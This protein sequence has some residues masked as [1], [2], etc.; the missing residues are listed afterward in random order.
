MIVVVIN[1]LIT[2]KRI[3]PSPSRFTQDG[4]RGLSS[5]FCI[6]RFIRLLGGLSSEIF[7]I[8]AKI[9]I[10]VLFWSFVP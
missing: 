5:N 1:P 7:D 8:A 9:L 6:Q 2:K 10:P 4:K 3:V